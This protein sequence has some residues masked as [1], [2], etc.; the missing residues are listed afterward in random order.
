MNIKRTTRD[1][2]G[3]FLKGV[4]MGAAD[5]VP[6]VSGGTIAFITG[7]YEELINTIKSFNPA[8]LR[9][10]FK[11]GPAAFWRQVNGNFLVV[12]LAGI[13]ASIAT[14]AGGV[15]FLL[16]HYPILLWAFFFG[17]ILASVWLVMSHI[18]KWDANL[19]SSFIIGAIIA[20][21]ITSLAPVSV[22]P[23]A[24]MVF[25]SGAIAICAM[26]LP[27]ISGSFILLLLGM[28][29]HILTAVKGADIQLIS[30]F[31]LGCVVGIM[32]FSRVLSWMFSHHHQVTLAL[33]SG[34]MLGSLNKVWPWKYTLSYTINRHGEQVPLLQDNVLPWH[35]ESITGQSSFLF[36]AVGLA[37]VGIAIVVVM[38]RFQAV[39]E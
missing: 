37:L 24:M 4:M 36:W 32:S 14:I 28:Y 29:A 30:L 33:L 8:A 18:K 13:V 23:T 11:Q 5:V 31:M 19:V 10:L 2:I 27:G 25:I 20:Y 39:K 1:F 7:I 38:E 12:L 16:S 35:F 34:F 6:G 17:L 21:L 22:E 3:L 26:I 15:L 9:V